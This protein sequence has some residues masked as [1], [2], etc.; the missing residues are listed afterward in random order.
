[1]R[2]QR[3][4]KASNI[5]RRNIFNLTCSSSF[6]STSSTVTLVWRTQVPEFVAAAC[7]DTSFL[8]GGLRDTTIANV[9]KCS[10]VFH[11]ILRQWSTVCFKPSNLEFSKFSTLLVINNTVNAQQ[12]K[13]LNKHLYATIDFKHIQSS[14]RGEPGSLTAL[15]MAEPFSG[16][17]NSVPTNSMLLSNWVLCLTVSLIWL[18]IC[19]FLSEPSSDLLYWR[20]QNKIIAHQER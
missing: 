7:R 10:H 4:I 2:L 15:S 8:H 5:M 13:D 6:Y 3:E 9:S 18:R 16:P 1:M 12:G 19:V 11:P 17:N 20:E 14:T